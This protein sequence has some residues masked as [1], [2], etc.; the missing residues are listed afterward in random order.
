MN[1]SSVRHMVAFIATFVT[2]MAY[3]AGYISGG[4]G[5]WWTAFATFIVY[6]IM[7]SLIDAGGHGGH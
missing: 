3:V 5:W 1:D 2:L 7:Y 4:F 6:G